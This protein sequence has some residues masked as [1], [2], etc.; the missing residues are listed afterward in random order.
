MARSF[1]SGEGSSVSDSVRLVS[2]PTTRRSAVLRC[3]VRMRGLGGRLEV[4]LCC[5]RARELWM[6]REK[7]QQYI[8]STSHQSLRKAWPRICNSFKHFIFVFSTQV[9]YFNLSLKLSFNLS[10]FMF[11]SETLAGTVICLLV[12]PRTSPRMS[13]HNVFCFFH[14]LY[15]FSCSI[16]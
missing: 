2:M 14:F 13:Y 9:S 5:E 10:D 8:G 4:A 1:D 7:K 3:R 12:L 15:V 11:F 6:R 16:L